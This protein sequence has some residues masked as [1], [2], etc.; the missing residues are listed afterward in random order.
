MAKRLRIAV[1]AAF[2]AVP[3]PDGIPRLSFWLQRALARRT[4]GEVEWVLLTPRVAWHDAAAQLW[5]LPNCRVVVTPLAGSKPAQIL[6]R[7]LLLPILALQHRADLL[8]NPIGNGPL[9]LPP[10]LPLAVV[11]CDVSWLDQPE[12]YSR[13]Y[14][15]VMPQIVRRVL[16]LARQ[17]ITISE[18]SAQQLQSRLGI[19]RDR[20]HV[21]LCL[22]LI[23]I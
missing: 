14:R 1:N 6:W 7:W 4:L 3:Q 22:S 15:L 5:E 2:L 21:M 13:G 12:V 8:F 19:G 17:V 20:L 10:G 16:A 11:V 23:H 18:Y 9:W